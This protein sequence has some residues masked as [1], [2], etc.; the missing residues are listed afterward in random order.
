MVIMEDK[1]VFEPGKKVNSLA[2]SSASR[3]RRQSHFTCVLFFPSENHI[4]Y[5]YVQCVGTSKP[6]RIRKSHDRL[7]G[8]QDAQ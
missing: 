7:P 5:R 8:C 1:E 2:V 4:T 3:V 6:A